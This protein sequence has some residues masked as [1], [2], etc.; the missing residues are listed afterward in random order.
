MRAL[1]RHFVLLTGC[2]LSIFVA[3]GWADQPSLPL[4]A[5]I[6]GMDAHALAWTK[7]I[8][9]PQATGELAD[10]TVVAGFPGGSPDI[11]QSMELLKAQV[12]PVAALGVEIVDSIDE[13]LQKVDV[14]MILSIDGRKHLEQVLPVFAAGKPV[15]V[16]K[17][18][19][20][21]LADA[22]EIFRLADEHK[23][24]CFSSSSLRFAKQTLN[25]RQDPRLGELVGCDQYAPCSLEPHHPDFF[26]Y[27]I[28]G[29]EPL[30]TIMGSGCVSVTRVHTEGTDMAVGVWQD[31]RI[32]TFRGIRNGQRGYGSTV[33]GTKGIVP[34]GGFD[35]YEPLI[36]EIVRFFKTGKPP[37]TA[38]QTL[39][40][41]AFM[42]AADESKRRGGSPVTL[43]SVMEKATLKQ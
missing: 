39:E 23:V 37:V 40:I 10:M 26:W 2:F 42:E 3:N 14:V 41:F 22:I 29:V 24:P 35:G 43:D 13:L 15:F 25:I 33:F 9:D 34:G 38:E 6:I 7:I 27:G 17:P 36:V 21:S 16:D 1:S 32:G 19:A 31:G 5:G 28:H 12:E 20:G 11:P 18:I 4:K 8:N 30:F